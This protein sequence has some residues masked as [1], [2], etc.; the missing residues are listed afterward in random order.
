MQGAPSKSSPSYRFV[1]FLYKLMTTWHCTSY[2][3]HLNLHSRTSHPSTWWT[4]YKGAVVSPTFCTNSCVIPS[5][6]MWVAHI[7]IRIQQSWFDVTWGWCR[8]G[9]LRR[10]TSAAERHYPM[11]KVRGSS[12][13]EQPHIQGAV[14]VQVQEGLEE[15]LHVQGQEGLRWG[16]T[17][18]PR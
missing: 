10:H 2:V 1:H 3:N 12:Q 9:R 11:S 18:H 8:S 16:D 4:D 14:A 17:P 15:L 13:Q 5:P 7:P 6:W